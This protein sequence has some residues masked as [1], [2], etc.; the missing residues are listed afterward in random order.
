MDSFPF[1]AHVC[2]SS[3]FTNLSIL[4]KQYMYMAIG[5]F[6][7]WHVTQVKICCFSNLSYLQNR[8]LTKST[9]KVHLTIKE[10]LFSFCVFFVA[11]VPGFYVWLWTD[12]NLAGLWNMC[13]QN[14]RSFKCLWSL[15]RQESPSSL[16]HHLCD[17]SDNWFPFWIE[18]SLFFFWLAHVNSYGAPH[19]YGKFCVAG[20]VPRQTY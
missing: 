8:A 12:L 18:A 10:V 14:L 11:K 16:T 9:S 1:W 3:D 17:M 15:A 5:L 2:M 19:R 13:N 20:L 7:C 6:S 4:W